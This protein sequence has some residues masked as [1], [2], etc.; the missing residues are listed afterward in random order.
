MTTAT[1]ITPNAAALARTLLD[2]AAQMDAAEHAIRSAIADAAMR[3]DLEAVLRIVK[4]WE[5]VPLAEVLK[6]ENTT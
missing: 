3:G 5:S 2:T 1:P 6:H 4:R